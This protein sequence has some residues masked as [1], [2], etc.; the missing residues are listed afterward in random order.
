[1][2]TIIKEIFTW[3]NQQ[4]IGT[5][6][7][8]IFFGRLVGKDSLGNKY[9]ENKNGKRWV[10]YNSE[11]EAT[12]IPDD[13]YSW[14]HYTKNKIEYLHNLKRYEWQKQHLSNQTGTDQSYHPNKKNN[15]IGKK[16]K[17]WKK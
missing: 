6:I 8:T 5:R 3:W 13:W 17:S 11:T 14:M 16:Y 9:Y 2:L 7:K 12:Q 1:M 15:E 4:T 10:I